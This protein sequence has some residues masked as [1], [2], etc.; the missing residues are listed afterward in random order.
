MCQLHFEMMFGTVEALTVKEVDF[1]D[2]T[3]FEKSI[4]VFGLKDTYDIHGLNRFF[5]VVA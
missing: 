2:K 5:L 3:T 1:I 4:A